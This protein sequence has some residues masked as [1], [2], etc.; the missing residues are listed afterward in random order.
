M[1]AAS[2]AASARM[3]AVA[4]SA[5]EALRLSTAKA[6]RSVST[7]KQ[8]EAAGVRRFAIRLRK[9]P[10]HGGTGRLPPKKVALSACS[11]R[12]I[13]LQRIA[14]GCTRPAAVVLAGPAVEAGPIAWATILLRSVWH[15]LDAVEGLLRRPGVSG[16]WRCLVTV[17]ISFC[18]PVSSIRISVW[19]LHESLGRL[20]ERSAVSAAWP[21]EAARRPVRADRLGRPSSALRK[22]AWAAVRQPPIGHRGALRVIIRLMEQHGVSQP[23]Q[24]PAQPSPTHV[25]EGRHRDPQAEVYRR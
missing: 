6:L 15:R 19:R 16:S 2:V 9:A 10:T 20:A 14:I 5:A 18:R 1:S 13:G 21:A 24:A 8:V 23:T 4:L 25:G 11:R 3:T 12:M 17:V 7:A 22:R